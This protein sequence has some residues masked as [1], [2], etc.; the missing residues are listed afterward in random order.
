MNLREICDKVTKSNAFDSF[1]Y[2]A[3]FFI[4]LDGDFNPAEEWQ[5]GFYNQKT[6]EV[7]SFVASDPVSVVEKSRAFRHDSGDVQELHLSKIKIDFDK[8]L[9][10]ARK[11]QQEKYKSQPPKQAIVILQVLKSVPTWNITFI[12]LTYSTLNIKINAE[13]GAVYKYDFGSLLQWGKK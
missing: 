7:E 4:M 8:A 3:H 5:V 6:K 1:G 11:F 12:T 9:E 10:I 13:T 2:L